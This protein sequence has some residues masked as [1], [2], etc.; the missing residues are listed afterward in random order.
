[1]GNAIDGGLG[2]VRF[3]AVC[4]L[5]GH[6]HANGLLWYAGMAGA[7]YTAYRPNYVKLSRAFAVELC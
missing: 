1:V 4:P 7:A 3:L 5:G 6:M 2:L